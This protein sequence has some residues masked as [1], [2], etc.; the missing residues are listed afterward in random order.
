MRA[1]M[2]YMGIATLLLVL[3]ASS[4]GNVRASVHAPAPET[5]A[6]ESTSVLFQMVAAGATY[7]SGI[8][9]HD[10]VLTLIDVAKET[11]VFTDRPERVAVA[12]STDGV[13]DVLF[14]PVDDPNDHS[15]YV[16]MCVASFHLLI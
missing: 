15:F 11:I 12:L 7:E 2:R 14:A 8:G 9:S 4:T 6:D 3:I 16:G 5:E 1:L 10:G 13:V